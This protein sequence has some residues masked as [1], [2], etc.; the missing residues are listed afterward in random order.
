VSGGASVGSALIDYSTPGTISIYN[1]TISNT[2]TTGGFKVKATI[3]D[4]NSPGVNNVASIDLSSLTITN[5]TGVS[6]NSTLTMT[7]GDTGFTQPTGPNVTVTSTISGTTAGT[8]S[9]NASIQFD[10]YL[11]TTNTQFGTQQ[12]L[13][14]TIHLDP[15]APGSSQSGNS[16]GTLVG[17]P[18]P[19]SLTQVAQITLANGDKLTD[20]SSG[21]TVTAPAPAGL[22]L[23]LS[24]IPVLVA[25]PLLR[26]VRRHS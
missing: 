13:I 23:A 22:L 18:I 25:R 3:A 4:S 1:L 24:C 6:G 14:P 16:V 2:G 11:D 10:S 5:Q 9:A 19:Y 12:L 20:G 17:T 21:T 15:I 8:N 26:R 7:T